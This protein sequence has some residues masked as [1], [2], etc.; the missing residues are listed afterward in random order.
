MRDLAL[1]L[2]FAQHVSF[3]ITF[4]G[5]INLTIRAEALHMESIHVMQVVGINKALGQDRGVVLSSSWDGIMDNHLG[6]NV[7]DGFLVGDFLLGS[8]RA[9]VS[10]NVGGSNGGKNKEGKGRASWWR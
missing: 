7:I 8:G 9:Q 6:G 1:V 2:L 3:G 5:D 10:L 4:L